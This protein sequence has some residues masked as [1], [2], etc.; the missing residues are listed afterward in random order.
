MLE[1]PPIEDLLAR[2][3]AMSPAVRAGSAKVERSEAAVALATR[4][5]KPDFLLSST[6]FNR[7]SLPDMWTFD[8]GLML[9]AYRGGK[10]QRAIAEAEARERADRAEQ[11][12][13]SLRVR[14]AVEK[15]H[16]EL[17][18]AVLEA[19]AYERGVLAVDGLAVESALAGFEAGRTPF[20]SVLEAHNTLYRDRWQH[21]ELL[22]HA[23]WHSALL[24]AFGMGE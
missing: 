2:A 23:L 10:Q 21:A 13:M 19:G 17:K 7:G 6:Y 18:A 22:F 4:R 12:A 8:V 14:A 3:E 20:L 24:D 16:A 5:L 1:V 9:P 15:A 11:Q